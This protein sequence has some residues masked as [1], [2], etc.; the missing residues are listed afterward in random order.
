MSKSDLK[1]KIGDRIEICGHWDDESLNKSKY[2][3][4][5]GTVVCIDDTPPKYGVKFDLKQTMFHSCNGGMAEGYGYW[6]HAR[7]MKA[8]SSKEPVKTDVKKPVLKLKLKDAPKVD[9]KPAHK[10]G[11]RIM[12]TAS[13]TMKFGAGTIVEFHPEKHRMYLVKFDKTHSALHNGNG[14]DAEYPNDTCWWFFD[15]EFEVLAKEIEIPLKIGEFNVI[16][17]SY[18]YHGKYFL[19]ID[20]TKP[21]VFT[22]TKRVFD[23]QANQVD[24][25]AVLPSSCTRRFISPTGTLHGQCYILCPLEYTPAKRMTHAEIEEKLGFKIEVV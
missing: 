1:F 25:I 13:G 22:E 23:M 3:G 7:N 15:G 19:E 20:S 9:E 21:M 17:K 2:Q 6:M 18:Q 14:C 24:L 12:P 16:P 5:K 11:T 8:S 4:L 10:I